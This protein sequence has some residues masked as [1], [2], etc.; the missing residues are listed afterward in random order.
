M[1]TFCD[2]SQWIKYVQL[3][4]FFHTQNQ[5]NKLDYLIAIDNRDVEV[6]DNIIIIIK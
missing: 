2:Q 3:K 1:K 5:S 6:F 4:L